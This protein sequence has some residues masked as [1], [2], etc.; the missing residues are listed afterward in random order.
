MGKILVEIHC[1]ATSKNYDFMLPD[2]MTV[3]KAI[4]KI[5]EEII[6]FENN[7]NLFPEINELL[8][9]NTDRKEILNPEY[10]LEQSGIY[11]G[12]RLMLL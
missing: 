6:L 4:E 5:R 7:Q 1:P 3:G 9:W 11:G 2:K 8:L 12:N 10:S